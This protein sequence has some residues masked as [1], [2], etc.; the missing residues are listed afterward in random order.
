M[1]LDSTQLINEVTMLEE[2]G[3]KRLILVFG[4][5]PDYNPSYI[6]E[7]VR[8]VYSVKEKNG[9]IRRVNINAA[10]LETEGFRTVK[11]SGI[12][13]IRYSRKPIIRNLQPISSCR[14]KKG[15]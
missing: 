1:T 6:A 14:Q 8:T 9:E 3:Q 7:V 4:E 10:P 12:G 2:Q 15:L 5:H 13:H 11:E